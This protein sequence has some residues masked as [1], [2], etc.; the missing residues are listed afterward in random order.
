MPGGSTGAHDPQSTANPARRQRPQAEPSWLHCLWSLQWSPPGP[1]WGL[2]SASSGPQIPAKDQLF[3]ERER[4]RGRDRQR[5]REGE[6]G[7]DRERRQSSIRCVLGGL[8]ATGSPLM[9]LA[10]VHSLMPSYP[11]SKSALNQQGFGDIPNIARLVTLV[12]PGGYS[13]YGWAAHHFTEHNSQCLACSQ[14]LT[15]PQDCSCT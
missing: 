11:A 8:N 6:R 13:T 14:H 5:D 9:S 2:C 3:E 15:P 12:W 7:G 4:E 10:V 1:P